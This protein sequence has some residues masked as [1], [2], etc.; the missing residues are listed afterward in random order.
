MDLKKLFVFIQKRLRKPAGR[1]IE[2][3]ETGLDLPPEN[4]A[5][6]KRLR[7]L[8][9]FGGVFTPSFLTIIG[10]IMYLRF[11]WIVANAG[12]LHTLVIVALA[13]SITFITSLSIAGLSTNMRM[14]T[15][16][17]YFI[18]SRVLGAPA[19]GSLG[20]SLF[21][22][23]AISIAL[24]TIG[25]CEAFSTFLPGI[26][27]R[28]L[29]LIVLGIITLLS[30]IGAGFM[31][32]I[33]YIIMAAI[34]LSF[35]SIFIN[36]RIGT[37][38]L[39]P[40]Y[41]AGNSFWIVFA[42]FFPAVTG[43]LA[44]V[45][46]SGDLKSP[47]KSIP[48]GIILAFGAGFLIYLAVPLF[49]AFTVDPAELPSSM[50]L[51]NA[52]RWPI[53]VTFGILGATLSS[54]IGSIL[55]AP[56]TLQA[57]AYDRIVPSFLGFGMGKTQE[58]LA[59]LLLSTLIAAFTIFL[60]DLNAVASIL[61]MFFLTAYGVLNLSATFETLVGNPSFRPSIKVAWPITLLGALACIAVMFL[62]DH[63]FAFAAWGIIIVIFFLLSRRSLKQEY[64]DIWEGVWHNLMIL[65]SR[66]LGA[67][68]RKSNKNWSPFIQLF[69]TMDEGHGQLLQFAADLT[70]DHGL[71]SLF[72]IQVGSIEKHA[73]E[74][75]S[76]QEEKTA[77][78]PHAPLFT[79]QIVSRSF[80][81]GVFISAQAEGFG[82][83]SYNTVLMGLPGSSRKDKENAL[84]LR[85]LTF[86]EKNILILKKGTTYWRNTEGPLTVWWGGQENNVRLMLILADLLKK[87]DNTFT[88]PI[89]LK[90]IV[91][92]PDMVAQVSE[93]L[94]S[95]LFDLRIAA[96]PE[97][98]VR[99]GGAT[100]VDL[101]REESQ[102]ASLVFMGLA[103][104]D[105]AGSRKF[106]QHLRS[107]SEGLSSVLFVRNNSRELPYE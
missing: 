77:A 51:T 46:M 84:L 48:R 107:F 74:A 49:L 20:I 58:P 53:L 6:G 75:E 57:L 63:V 23:Q 78:G 8:G 2:A 18:I 60:G 12:L 14:E 82:A 26:P 56:R 88:R 42:V 100:I 95:T 71:Y 69:A 80:N 11:G 91:N 105:R 87:S 96:E 27:I 70:R 43:I 35:V 81:D 21:L 47:E 7:T 36:F 64:G 37:P 97:V 62:I 28:T 68:E 30:I 50:A 44:G 61:T 4:E 33:Q 92:S 72:T 90:S 83:G 104:P 13:N 9:T 39:A 106:Y 24:Y 103:I 89:L 79:K 55:A 38:Y 41:M 45:S 25:F 1:Q 59:A 3:V 54:A 76:L 102:G 17:A 10:V 94:S 98:L 15:G 66:K 93:L 16:G 22:S 85:N 73:K 5:K 67:L 99:P 19:G 65:G 40:N 52:S 34:L 32:K 86:I 101:I 31:I 29:T